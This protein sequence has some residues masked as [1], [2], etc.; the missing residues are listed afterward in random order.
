M[1]IY[2]TDLKGTEEG[3]DELSFAHKALP[4]HTPISVNSLSISLFILAKR[5]QR[6]Y[7]NATENENGNGGKDE[8]TVSTSRDSS[9]P[10][11]GISNIA[12]LLIS[13]STS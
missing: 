4:L 10:K 12:L 1:V 5:E 9:V 11:N 13:M 6:M 3:T 7:C 2:N 8:T